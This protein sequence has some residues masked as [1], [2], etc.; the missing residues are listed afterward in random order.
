ME[1]TFLCYVS[2][3][4]SPIIRGMDSEPICDGSPKKRH[5]VCSQSKN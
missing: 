1:Y 4:A 2:P 5:T 3:S